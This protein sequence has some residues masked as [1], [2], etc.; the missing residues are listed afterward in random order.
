M[1][2]F[3]LQFDPALICRLAERY[4]PEQDSETFAA[5]ARIAAGEHTLANLRVIVRWKSAR[6]VALIDHNPST[7]IEKSLRFVTNPSTS[8]RAAIEALDRLH[9]V[10][11]P[12]ASAIMTAIYPDKFTVTDWR[13]LEALGVTKW[14]DN[15]DFYL[16]YL[17][18]C[19]DLA[20]RYGVSLRALDRALWQWS[21]ERGLHNSA[22][23]RS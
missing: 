4:G 22:V 19:R 2:N 1:L 23:T 12:M 21:R 3:V 11:I 17:S 7:E 16:A 20:R 9:G 18:A 8:E 14:P 15:V 6:R 13:A 5:G 10:G